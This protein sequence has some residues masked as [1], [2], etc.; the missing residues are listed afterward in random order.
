MK[1]NIGT[2]DKAVRISAA[3]LI[4]VL[5]FSNII[6]GLTAILLLVVAGL[7]IATSFM[8]FC[9]LYSALG[10]T[11]SKKPLKSNG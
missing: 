9:P 8:S 7:F 3:I 4:I 5:Y 2:K 6:N 11:T 10:I 1:K